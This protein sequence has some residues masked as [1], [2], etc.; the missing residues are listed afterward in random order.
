V[1]KMVCII[2]DKEARQLASEIAK[3]LY[4]YSKH[5][6]LTKKFLWTMLYTELKRSKINK[7]RT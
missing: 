3:D 7:T 1:R 4:E 2:D 5:M 6:K